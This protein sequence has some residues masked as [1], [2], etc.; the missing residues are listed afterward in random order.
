V[1]LPWASPSTG[2]RFPLA[3]AEGATE[4]ATVVTEVL[5]GL[6]RYW[7]PSEPDSPPVDGARRGRPVSA[8]RHPAGD[9]ANPASAGSG[10]LAAAAA[11]RPGGGRPRSRGSRV[12]MAARVPHCDAVPEV[13]RG[14]GG[15]LPAAGRVGA[16]GPHRPHLSGGSRYPTRT[17]SAVP[18]HLRHP[19]PG[20]YTA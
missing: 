8:A 17:P 11:A 10:G 19:S 4:N 1:W 18:G 15:P 7:S 13:S 20:G 9:R 6:A 5:V 14:R 2:P 3:L 12:A 16:Q